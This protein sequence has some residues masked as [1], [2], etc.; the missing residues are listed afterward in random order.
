MLPLGPFTLVEPI[1]RGGMGEVW[2]GMHTDTKLPVAVKVVREELA[3]VPAH[4][5]SFRN[6]VRAMARLDHP[7]ILRVLDYGEVDAEAA[8]ASEG[9]LLEGSPYF[10]MEHAGGGSLQ[11]LQRRLSWPDTRR[12][13]L[14]LLDA[15]AHAHARGV[16]HRDLKAGNVLIATATDARPGLKLADFGIAHA[17]AD[18][19]HRDD[20]SESAAGTLNY[21]AQEQLAGAWREYG[22]WTDL[23]A[24]SA[25]AWRLLTGKPPFHQVPRDRML[26]AHRQGP[27]TTLPDAAGAPDGLEAW[28]RRQL[29]PEPRHRF[30]RAAD[31]AWALLSLGEP[32]DDARG[33]DVPVVAPVAFDSREITESDTVLGPMVGAALADEPTH[34]L[35]GPASKVPHIPLDWRRLRT[36]PIPITLQGAGL[37]LF[38]LRE[39]SLVGRE[40]ER[41][42]LWSLL[43]TT[44][45]SRRGQFAVLTGPHGAGKTHL[46]TWLCARAHE[47]GAATP[48]RHQGEQLPDLLRRHL[49]ITGLHGP[50][51]EHQLQRTLRG[52]GAPLLSL[53]QRLLEGEI[54]DRIERFGAVHEVLQYLIDRSC[55]LGRQGPGRPLLLV[56]E[57]EGPSSEVG[58][59]ARW[60]LDR[61]HH[62]PLPVFVVVVATAA[63][64]PSSGPLARL[65]AGGADGV[66]LGP[67]LPAERTELVEGLLRLERSL[68]AHVDEASAGNPQLAVGMVDDLVQ[69]GV[70]Q[71]TPDGFALQAGAAP[72]LPDALQALWKTRVADL[73][74]GLAPEATSDLER[75]AALGRDIDESLWH[76]LC[77]DPTAAGGGRVQLRPEGLMRRA[78]VVERLLRAHLAEETDTGFRFA[79]EGIRVSLLHQAQLHGRA[80]GHHAACVEALSRLPEVDPAVLGPQLRRAG[81]LQRAFDV[82]LRGAWQRLDRTEWRSALGLLSEARA[83]LE[84]LQATAD[85]PRWP[86]LFVALSDGTRG[87]GHT[88]DAYRYASRAVEMARAH[89]PQ[90]LV[91]ALFQAAQSAAATHRHDEILPL[92][93]ELE[94]LAE[95][96]GAIDHGR[97]VF[98]RGTHLLH[99]GDPRMGVAML[100]HARRLFVRCDEPLGQAN[101]DRVL[102][103]H[104]LQEGDLPRAEYL[105]SSASHTYEALGMRSTLAK[106]WAA[107]GDVYRRA[108]RLDEADQLLARLALLQQQVGSGVGAVLLHLNQGLVRVERRDWQGAR[109]AFERATRLAELIRHDAFLGAAWGSL[110]APMAAL[111]DWPAFDGAL[112]RART[113]LNASGFC[114]LDL[115]ATLA[116]AAE[117]ATGPRREALDALIAAQKA[118]LT[119]R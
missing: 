43:V 104:A 100:T 40:R 53:A 28:L 91:D 78:E 73:L 48:L 41:D 21:M 99:K 59:F 112:A 2:R 60:L 6:E 22:P 94:P 57:D 71:A 75:A 89:A 109:R 31:A 51:L 24:L 45:Q 49:R 5:A 30:T 90:Q 19:H 76:L 114:D 46:T 64:R 13:L 62:A 15:L 47:L 34:D 61:Q 87:A 88:D 37:G 14:S 39:V 56:L 74:E 115:A 20:R 4:V 107:L 27:S 86:E 65:I 96:R 38:P 110:L 92:L 44:F 119:R 77:E 66:H 116:L 42:Q 84:A 52:G 83:V 69:R 117:H 36:A 11:N 105:L 7:C 95:A 25:L 63:V 70:L 8:A 67:L 80:Q 3:R 33:V 93:D 58:A 18:F 10:A 85:D 23:F 9:F 108:G 35:N 81:A 29:R 98:A 54:T 106:T 26:Q 102:G 97:C 17:F 111:E 103:Q 55:G 1:A 50:A 113:A 68:A 82:L 79:H 101:V 16:V 72:Q 118:G 12:V 32:E